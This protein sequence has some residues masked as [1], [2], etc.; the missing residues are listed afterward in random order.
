ME[1][2]ASTSLTWPSTK[3]WP[4]VGH[5]PGMI[6]LGLIPFM[7]SAWRELGDCFEFRAGSE[8]IKCVVH[9]DD[10][11]AM[12]LSR[13]HKYVKGAS[14]D[15]FR[16]LVGMGLV[17]SEG[18]LWR[19]QRRLIQPT[20]YRDTVRKFGDQMVALTDVMLERWARTL[21]GGVTFNVHAEL[22]RLALEIIGKAL[23]ELEFRDD[24]ESI[25]TRDF[26]DAM[27]ILVARVTAVIEAPRW[28]PTPG[29]IRL[30]RAE[31]A[32]DRVVKRIIDDRR[33]SG[34]DHD[35]L[36]GALLRGR[37]EDGAPLDDTQLRDEVV[38]MFLAG[39]ETTAVGIGWTVWLLSQHRAA[40][41]KMIDEID[42]VLGQRP[43]TIADLPK[44]GYVKQ[45]FYES[46][47]IISPV[48]ATAR[49]CV[50][51]DILGPGY[52][53]EPGTRVMNVIWLTHKHPE[54]W[55]A[56]ERFEPERFEPERFAAQHKFAF[57]P[58]NDGPRKCVGEHFATM[59]SILVLTRMFQRFVVEPAPGFEPEM[60]FQLATRPR[61]G[62][63]MQLRERDGSS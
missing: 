2:A 50:E 42:A 48:W 30:E 45:V 15:Q 52:P 53:V 36:L 62:L 14:Y 58:F 24:G 54:F 11:E 51:P 34:T 10:I 12:L 31:A 5:I 9:P 56:P 47:R 29:N 19:R 57:L 55:P 17:S 39:H 23:F 44:L 61:N 20:F 35:D 38:T 18:D 27:R 26:S 22:M 8:V 37:D 13:R 4:V 63:M 49:N 60:D 1:P 6:S 59:E 25:S 41:D 46:M 21:T 3:A 16:R 33:R 28:V 43:P 40:R 32:L 7:E